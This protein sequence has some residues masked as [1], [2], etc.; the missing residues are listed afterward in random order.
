MTVYL[1]WQNA[2]PEPYLEKVFLHKENAEKC[3][4]VMNVG[5]NKGFWSLLA[6]IEEWEF[7]DSEFNKKREG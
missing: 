5:R 3:V 7:S 6:Y 2:V 4:E 1:V